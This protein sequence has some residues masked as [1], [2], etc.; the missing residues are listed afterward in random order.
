MA[1]RRCS[2]LRKTLTK[3]QTDKRWFVCINFCGRIEFFSL[4]TK[5]IPLAYTE[6]QINSWSLFMQEAANHSHEITLWRRNILVIVVIVL[7]VLYFYWSINTT[8]AGSL[9]ER[10]TQVC[11]QVH[12]W[13]EW[14]SACRGINVSLSEHSCWWFNETCP[15][16]YIKHQHISILFTATLLPPLADITLDHLR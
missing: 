13:L 5:M 14:T 3:E 7:L 4:L 1:V 2:W 8:S 9:A 16:C 15:L 10:E 12:T 6:W 11:S